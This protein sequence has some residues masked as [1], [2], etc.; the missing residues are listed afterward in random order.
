LLKSE[1][2]FN[3]RAASLVVE[4]IESLEKPLVTFPTGMTPRGHVSG[5]GGG[6]S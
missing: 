4:T 1:Q 5:A 2:K 3:L 6:I